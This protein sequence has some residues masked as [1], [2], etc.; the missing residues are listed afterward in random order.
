MGVQRKTGK[1]CFSPVILKS[2]DFFHGDFIFM[3]TFSHFFP[4]FDFLTG[5][6]KIK[7]VAVNS[8]AVA[9]FGRWLLFHSVAVAEVG[10]KTLSHLPTSAAG[11]FFRLSRQRGLGFFS[12][13]AHS[14]YL[15]TYY[16]P[17]FYFFFTLR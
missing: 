14:K 11:D 12:R 2:F 17:K 15:P 8:I 3:A 13:L 9:G 16:S 7:V 6:T 1:F 5:K 10:D 4:W